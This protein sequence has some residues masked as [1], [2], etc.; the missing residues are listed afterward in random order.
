MKAAAVGYLMVL[1]HAAARPWPARPTSITG[2]LA[3]G[4]RA[5]AVFVG[6]PPERTLELRGG[7]RRGAV[8]DE[9]HDPD[10]MSD[11]S[12]A[13]SSW[14][15][16]S[17]S[18][19]GPEREAIRHDEVQPMRAIYRDGAGGLGSGLG[20]DAPPETE[21]PS[22]DARQPGD[23]APA[24]ADKLRKGKWDAV[25]NEAE[26]LASGAGGG[27]RK[28]KYKDAPDEATAFC[29]MMQDYGENALGPAVAAVRPGTST[30]TV[31][32]A[33]LACVL[34]SQGAARKAVAQ[35]AQ[36]LARETH[37]G[38]GHLEE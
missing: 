18:G 21:A 1:A 2:S 20:E 34:R 37:R 22:K 12:P 10:S 7:G 16:S 3:L 17:L 4:G 28:A 24:P 14:R 19:A 33:S 15:D 5:G 27:L 35:A 13:V 9:S 36:Q 32:P 25:G 11:A 30:L 8:D 29:M 23:M 6:R 31:F 26:G 38:D